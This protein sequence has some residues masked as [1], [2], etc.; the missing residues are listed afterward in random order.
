MCVYGKV[1]Y[2][3]THTEGERERDFKELPHVIME[4]N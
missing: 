1:N 4:A 2:T 3:H